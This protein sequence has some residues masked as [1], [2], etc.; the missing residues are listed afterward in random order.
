[1]PTSSASDNLSYNSVNISMPTTS[2]YCPQMKPDNY[3]SVDI[4]NTYYI[5]IVVVVL[6]VVV[7]VFVGGGGGGGGGHGVW[8]WWWW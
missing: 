6:L 1:M 3:N 5:S 4:F 8:W 2:A 7:V